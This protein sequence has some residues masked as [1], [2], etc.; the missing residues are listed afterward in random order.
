[1]FDED[2]SRQQAESVTSYII[3]TEMN[4]TTLRNAEETL[5]NALLIAVI[6][7]GLPESL[8][9]FSI[10]ITQSEKKI[11]FREFKTKL[12]SYKSTEKFNAN[13]IDDSTMKASDCVKGRDK[14]R[15]EIN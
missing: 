11:T 15:S 6:L 12:R 4:I 2:N 5:S 13:S 3:H 10:P 9:L 7:R 14:D 8:K 1:M